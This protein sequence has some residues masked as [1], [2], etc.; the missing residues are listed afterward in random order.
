M[1]YEQTGLSLFLSEV[2]LLGLTSDEMLVPQCSDVVTVGVD[3]GAGTNSCTSSRTIAET[4]MHT[5][6]P[7]F[8]KNCFE[9]P[10]RT[11]WDPGPGPVESEGRS[12]MR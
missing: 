4:T 10:R 12:K 9:S 1:K 7:L 11:W 2:S 5:S 8:W 3:A 6:T